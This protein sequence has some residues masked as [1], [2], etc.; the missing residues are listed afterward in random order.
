MKKSNLRSVLSPAV[1]I[2]LSILA[3]ANPGRGDDKVIATER[4]VARVDDRLLVAGELENKLQPVFRQLEEA[5]SG[6]EL[7]R[8]ES[9]ARENAIRNWV[10]RELIRKQVRKTD[11]IKITPSEVDT[12]LEEIRGVYPTLAEYEADLAKEGLTESKL[13][14]Q[15]EDELKI[16]YLV[17]REIRLKVNVSPGEIIAY[18]KDSQEE[19]TEPEMVRF[20]HILIRAGEDQASLELAHDQAEKILE[21]LD[22]GESFEA[23]ARSHSQGPRAEQGGDWGFVEKGSLRP[24]LEEVVFALGVD[25]N[26]RLIET[27][28]GFHIVRVTARR[29]A[30]VKPLEE[31]WKD[32]ELK[33]SARKFE[34]LFRDWIERLRAESYVVISE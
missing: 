14:E 28:L 25:E 2:F 24:S 20:S 13:R 23:L 27:D 11:E 34:E 7:Q 17:S 33:L 19:F 22:A 6:D 8:M 30:S 5:Y 29:A 3:W 26:S 15:I 16:Q 1:I 31:V 4:V 12:R 32:I 9:R 10:E 21:K 18:Y